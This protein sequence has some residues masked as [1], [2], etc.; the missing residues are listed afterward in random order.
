M[1]INDCLRR[2]RKRVC[3]F[4]S[5][6]GTAKC[7]ISYSVAGSERSCSEPDV[8]KSSLWEELLF[9]CTL[10][11]RFLLLVDNYCIPIW[12]PARDWSVQNGG[13]NLQFLLL[14]RTGRRSSSSARRH[15]CFQSKVSP[16]FVIAN[17]RIQE[18]RRL[19]LVVVPKNCSCGGGRQ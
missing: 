8:G 4:R 2:G 13:S 11:R 14:S 9:E 5:S 6:K 17:N 10:Q 7:I 3:G 19:L 15:A 18:Q 16:L 1:E 12:T